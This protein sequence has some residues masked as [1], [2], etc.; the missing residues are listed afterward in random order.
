MKALTYDLRSMFNLECQLSAPLFQRPYV[1]QKEEQWEPLWNDIRRIAEALANGQSCKPHFL[2]AVVLEHRAVPLGKPDAR[3]IIDGQQRLTT[4]QLLMEA[5]R[6]LGR[7]DQRVALQRGQI[8]L[9]IENRGVSHP[10]ERFK[11]WPTNVDRPVYRAIMET[12]NPEELWARIETVCHGSR[13]RLAEAYDYFHEVIREWLNSAGEDFVLRYQA[14]VN[15]IREKLRLVVIDMDEQD[16]AQVIFETLNARGTPLLPSDLVKNFLFFQAQQKG[17]NVDQLYAE[18]WETFD[19]ND[20]FWR[21]EVGIGRLKRPRI[22]IFLQHFLALALN[23]SAALDAKTHDIVI[24][25]LFR[26]YKTFASKHGEKNIEWQLSEFSR[27]ARHFK[28]MEEMP[29]DSSEGLFFSRLRDMQ[30]TTVYPFVLGLF[31]ATTNEKQRAPVLKILESYLVRRMVCRL[32]TQGYNRL[33]LE[34]LQAVVKGNG[35][36][37][38]CVKEFLLNENAD[39]T[40][41]PDD[42]EVHEAFLSQPLFTAITRP[43]LRFVLRAID[44]A[45]Q[46][47]KSEIQVLKKGLTVEHLLPQHWGKHWPL[48]QK[49]R[50]SDEAFAERVDTRNHLLHTIGNL[51]LLNSSLNPTVSNGGFK[52]K[53]REILRHSKLNLNLF[54]ADEDDWDEKRI[55][56]RAEKLFRHFIKVWPHPGKQESK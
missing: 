14:L 55:K 37:E 35:Y 15:T 12:A 40:R 18:H 31:D 8:E 50:E 44:S 39:S 6:D 21:E 4:L 33:F 32:T 34:L 46:S 1:W 29:E 20:S 54:L 19:S 38:A 22:D 43:R 47:K 16:D 45:M 17:E 49:E 41:W 36:T 48:V 51:T 23:Q 25:E 27:H 11:V 3:W 13:S 2:G 24:T 30:T 10:D 42:N 28:K 9:L 56:A 7:D 52:A 5:V 53:K 26:E